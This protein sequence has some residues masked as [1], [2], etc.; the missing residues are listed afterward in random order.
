MAAEL[1]VQTTLG[2]LMN[3]PIFSHTQTLR[4]MLRGQ[5]QEREGV[6]M[7]S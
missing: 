6:A 3:T 5:L 4:L 7:L 2:M 1:T